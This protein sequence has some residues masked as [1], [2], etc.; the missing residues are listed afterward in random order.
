MLRAA[1][2][3]GTLA[4][5]N[6][7]LATP[8]NEPLPLH[9]LISSILSSETGLSDRSWRIPARGTMQ[10]LNQ[11]LANQPLL[12]LFNATLRGI[13]QVIF[14]NNPVSGLLILIAIFIQSPWLGTMSL[15]GT[16]AAN[17]MA[18]AVPPTIS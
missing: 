1:L 16:A 14:V 8:D 18:I 5:V 2:A 9:E 3:Y 17:L 12:D 10:H 6:R 15:L 7:S 13:G 4:R 11:R